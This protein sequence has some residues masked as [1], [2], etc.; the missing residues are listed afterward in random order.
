MEH[1]SYY[2]IH[3]CPL[4]VPILSQNDPVHTTTST[5]VLSLPS[6]SGSDSDDTDKI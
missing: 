2:R 6:T 4:T 3:T 1:E 5:L